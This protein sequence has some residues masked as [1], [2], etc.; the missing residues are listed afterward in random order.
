MKTKRYGDGDGDGWGYQVRVLK[1][2]CEVMVIEL[3][4]LSAFSQYTVQLSNW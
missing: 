3:G 4:S 1:I 2:G